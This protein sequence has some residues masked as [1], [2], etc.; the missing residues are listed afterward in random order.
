MNPYQSVL[1]NLLDGDW[2]S[3]KSLA[4]CEFSIR[5]GIDISSRWNVKKERK[6][7][8]TG[9]LFLT[10]NQALHSHDDID[11]KHLQKGPVW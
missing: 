7:G 2:V 9:L 4:I 6:Y 5:D 10:P 3:N 8:N 1:N 11:S